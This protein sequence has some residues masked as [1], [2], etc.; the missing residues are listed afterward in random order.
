V[1]LQRYRKTL[2]HERAE[3]VNRL[4]KVLETA[5]IK[6]SCVAADILGKSG[7]AMIA[8]LIDGESSA[9]ELADLARGRLKKKIPEL[10]EALLG[11]VDDHHRILLTHLL[12]HIEF[13]EGALEQL[14]RQIQPYL[15]PYE[16]AV[17]L[18]VS[19]PGIAEE[20]AASILSEIGADMSCFPSAAHLAGF[21][22]AL[23]WQSTERRQATQ[24]QDQPGQ[25][26]SESHLSRGCLGHCPYEGELP[27]S[28]I[29]SF[30]STYRQKEGSHS[31]LTQHHRY[32]L[33]PPSRQ[34]A[35]SRSWG[36]LL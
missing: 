2:V 8:G 34:E 11:R 20:S 13:L 5:N 9:E 24:K 18:L 31:C 7:R 26:S 30:G 23:S 29:S 35:L 36:H 6:L 15:A 17:E 14:Y 10:R 22:R 1:S 25:C 12:A 28:S 19:I 27:V 16:G 3:E 32:H 33:P 21:R 4:Q